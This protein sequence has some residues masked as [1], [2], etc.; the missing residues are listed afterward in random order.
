MSFFRTEELQRGKQR[1]RGK[2]SE[3]DGLITMVAFF[4]WEGRGGDIIIKW[5]TESL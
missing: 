2:C 3:A 4:F 1:Q 5:Q